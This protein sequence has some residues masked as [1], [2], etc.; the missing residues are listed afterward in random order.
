[1]HILA[2]RWRRPRRCVDP[3]T[4][5]QG[6]A[7]RTPATGRLP[8]T[9]TSQMTLWKNHFFF[10]NTGANESA[11]PDICLYCIVFIMPSR[12]LLCKACYIFQ[13]IDGSVMFLNNQEPNARFYRIFIY[14]FCN[15]STQIIFKYGLTTNL[16]NFKTFSTY[17]WLTIVPIHAD[18]QNIYNK[19]H[20]IQK[21]NRT[22]P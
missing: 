16:P 1:M 11:L 10:Q 9:V 18:S 21:N 4:A 15:Y 3:G 6:K 5:A 12:T 7:P 19:P 2:Q 17:I 20:R 14:I 8:A 13:H 22:L